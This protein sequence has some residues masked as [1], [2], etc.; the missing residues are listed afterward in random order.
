M[1]VWCR[2]RGC[3][4]GLC[5]SVLCSCQHDPPS[6]S[7]PIRRESPLVTTTAIAHAGPGLFNDDPVVPSMRAIATDLSVL[8]SPEGGSIRGRPV[9]EAAV[10]S[11][12]HTVV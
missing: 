1:R 2:C 10:L 8:L 11:I 3:R 7:G 5:E 12:P 9:V 6:S 4:G